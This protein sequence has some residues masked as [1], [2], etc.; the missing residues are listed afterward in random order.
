[1]L[2]ENLLPTLDLSGLRRPD[3]PVPRAVLDVV[4]EGLEPLEKVVGGEFFG[5]A[6]DDD[7]RRTATFAVGRGRARVEL[8]VRK[9]R[10]AWRLAAARGVVPA[11]WADDPRRCFPD[12]ELLFFCQAC[13]GLGATGWNYDDVCEDCHGRGNTM[14][15][16][17]VA[18]PTS[19][20]EI[21]WMLADPLRVERSEA[22]ARE[23]MRR[24]GDAPETPSDGCVQWGRLRQG[25][26]YGTIGVVVTS[27]IWKRTRDTVQDWDWERM[28]G[29][30][31]RQAPWYAEARE[32]HELTRQ[33]LC[34]DVGMAWAHRAAGIA[35]SPLE[36][37]LQLWELGV[38]IE[39]MSSEAI[40]LERVHNRFIRSWRSGVPYG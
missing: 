4:V 3:G 18:L 2:P 32:L 23:V 24:L 26:P 13:N 9:A 33:I 16:G 40:V 35:D 30:A 37:V 39:E 14:Q 8:P 34:F 19:V 7:P 28:Q 6:D 5:S 10:D 20:Q 1:M 12:H 17:R 22:L 29:P 15:R 11:S 21:L 38:M 25:K 36:P 27:P 31:F